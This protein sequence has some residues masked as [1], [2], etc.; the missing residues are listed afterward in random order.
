MST[1]ASAPEAPETAVA[2]PAQ[3]VGWL[4]LFYDLVHV[5]LLAAV[6]HL[7]HGEP[8]IGRMWAAFGLLVVVWTVWFNE[9]QATNLARG[10]SP[11]QR[12]FVLASMAGVAVMAVGVPDV[13]EGEYLTFVIGYAMAR[14]AMA[15]VWIGQQRLTGINA[16]RTALVS[17]LIAAA[18][19]LSYLA[20][21]QAL[22]WVALVLI[23]LGVAIQRPRSDAERSMTR[24]ERR[25][26][27]R[28]RR[29][30]PD[31]QEL[32][33]DSG[34]LMERIGLFVM[35]CFGES[36]AQLVN[37]TSEHRQWL[38]A[39]LGLVLVGSLFWA[40]YDVALDRVE[41][42]LEQAPDR[43]REILGFGQIAIVAG[44]LGVAAGLAGAIEHGM[45][46][47][48]ESTLRLLA[49]GCALAMLGIMSMSMDALRILITSARRTAD[50]SVAAGDVAPE[51]ER[52]RHTDPRRQRVAVGWLVLVH[53][54]L[55]LLGPWVVLAFGARMP[56]AAVLVLLIAGP[57]LFVG[58]STAGGRRPPD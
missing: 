27:R 16:V 4:E 8:S 47:Q 14:F 40:F 43:L 22:F 24:R 46:H 53:L 10:I 54:A 29:R 21:S 38:V 18:A 51:E 25:E 2:P 26:S 56:T 49:G 13:V 42:A 20:G 52:D 23:E 57:A 32:H 35:L 44:I 30:D 50:A 1:A 3:K 34:H 12:G 45:G 9:V 31:A 58:T 28:A 37:T 19:V 11:R 15:P 33:F 55:A 36:V 48:P 17:P 7:L 6:T 41:H 39:G 5:T